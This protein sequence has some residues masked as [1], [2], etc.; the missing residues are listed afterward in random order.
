MNKKA[1]L[2]LTALALFA[3]GIVGCSSPK[4]APKLSPEVARDMAQQGKELV[5]TGKYEEA[6]KALEQVAKTE[7]ADA[8]TFLLLGITRYQKKDYNGAIAAYDQALALDSKLVEAYQGKANTFRDMNNLREAEIWYRKA[9]SVNPQFVDAY[10][11]LSIQLHIAGKLPEA[12]KVMQECVTANPKSPEMHVVL[13]NLQKASG[14][15]SEAKTTYETALTL[16]PNNEAAK[17]A[18]AALK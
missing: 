1:R 13:G 12:I 8:K 16:D 6:N 9:W 7:Q 10:T 17:A 18:L 3:A 11:E 14:Q 2:V 15:R 4:V 5:H